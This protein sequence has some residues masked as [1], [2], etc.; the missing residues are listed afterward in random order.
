MRKLSQQWRLLTLKHNTVLIMLFG[1]SVAPLHSDLWD[2]CCMLHANTAAAFKASLFYLFGCVLF[3]NYIHVSHICMQ[4]CLFIHPVCPATYDNILRVCFWVG[5]RYTNSLWWLLP[6]CCSRMAL[7]QVKGMVHTCQRLQRAAN[8]HTHNSAHCM[9]IGG[10]EAWEQFCERLP[11]VLK[12][13]L[14]S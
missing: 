2:L 1:L 10:E 3:F 6:V 11:L 8:M 4:G 7:L 9:L 5:G 14:A 12:Y 13:C